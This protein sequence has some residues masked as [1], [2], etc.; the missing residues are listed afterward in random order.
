MVIWSH[1][2]LT[3]KLKLHAQTIFKSCKRHLLALSIYHKKG[4][5][6][7]QI[8]MLKLVQRCETHTEAQSC[9]ASYYILMYPECHIYPMMCTVKSSLSILMCT[10]RVYHLS[11]AHC[12]KDHSN[13]LL[14]TDSVLT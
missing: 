11:Y 7:F 14:H 2:I 6:N 3:E 4:P 8:I 10:I 5:T 9:K 13:M 12:D 1:S